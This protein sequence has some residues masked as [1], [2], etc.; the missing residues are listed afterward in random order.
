VSNETA[1]DIKKDFRQNCR[2]FGFRLAPCWLLQLSCISWLWLCSLAPA[3]AQVSFAQAELRGRVLDGTHA[4]LADAQITIGAA[5]ATSD[6]NGEFALSAAPAKYTLT[7]S[8]EGFTSVSKDIDLPA[9]GIDVEIALPVAPVNSTVTVNE[10]AGYLTG[11]TTSATKNLTPLQDVPQSITVINR[12][13]I[14]DQMMMSI[15]DVVNYVPGVTAIQGENNRDQI[16]IRGNS[17]SAD[18]FLNGVRDDVQY[19]RDLY[20]LERVEVLKGPNAL[21]FGRGGAGGV[22]NRVPK[23]ADGMSQREI[24]LSGGSFGDKRVAIDLDQPL[25]SKV[26]VRLNGM[27]ENAGTFRDYVNLERSGINPTITFTPS[28][29]TRITASYENFRDNRG[30]DRGI[31]SFQGKPV[32]IGVNTFFGNP[33]YNNVHALANIGTIAIEHQ[34]RRVHITNRTSIADYDRGYQNFVPGAVSADGSMDSLSAYNNATQRRNLF[35]QTDASIVVHTGG[36]RHTLL[37]GFEFG[38]QLTNNFRNTGY[39]NNTSATLLVPIS[40][41]VI[42][43][44]VTFRQS[45]TDANNHVKTNL[46]AAY[47]QDQIEVSKYIQIIAGVR[48]DYFDL[49]YHDNRSGT[50]LRRIDHLISPRAGLVFKPIQPLSFYA[51]YS[52]SWLPS[53]GDQFSSLTTI[54][55]QVKPEKFSNYEVGAKWDL[56]KRFALTSAVYR[57]DRIVQ[58]G[59]Q[60]TNGFEIG[61]TGNITR[62]W[63]VAG[64]YAWQDAF[65]TSSTTSARAGA[66]VAQVPHNTFSLWNNYKVTSRLGVGVGFLNRSDMFAAVDNTVTLPGYFR[67]D[68][69]IYYSV[70]EHVRLQVNAQNLFDRKYYLNADN[71]TNITPGSPRAFVAALVTRF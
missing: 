54:T 70:T 18:F 62:R 24:T 25:G 49:Q 19:F 27:Y 50:N 7:V 46:G 1:I 67:T 13:Q 26:A 31:P 36:I 71:N 35:N 9:E 23:E 63:R 47:A 68:G 38:R 51:S 30:S 15:A 21:M 69:A 16:V 65:I 58:T 45:A 12:E 22:V 6:R 32:D 48:F 4:P 43:T 60:R 66:Q 64:G 3:S 56:S 20:N 2:W 14:Q 8:K 41:P 10:A 42:Q 44:P 11:V 37:G 5:N 29:N 55:Q 40:N 61:V 53:S 28:Q 57:L 59:S 52:V 34:A 39:F 17:T 33:A